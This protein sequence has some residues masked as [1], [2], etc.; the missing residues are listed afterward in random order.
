[1]KSVARRPILPVVGRSALLLFMS[2]VFVVYV[3]GPVYWLFKTSIEPEAQ[4]AAVPP[5][6]IPPKRG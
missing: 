4:V 2:I 6:W 5:N 1:M 3:G